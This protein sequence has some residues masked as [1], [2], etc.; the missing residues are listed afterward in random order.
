MFV[1]TDFDQL[2]RKLDRRN[3]V[4]V[5]Q[6]S[7]TED[8][9]EKPSLWI[10]AAKEPIRKLEIVDSDL[11]GRA[12]LSDLLL[13]GPDPNTWS[14]RKRLASNKKLVATAEY[15]A[16]VFIRRNLMVNKAFGLL[17]LIAIAALIAAVIVIEVSR[18]RDEAGEPVTRQQG[19]E[20]P[21]TEKDATL[22]YPRGSSACVNSTN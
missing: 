7:R 22:C 6:V 17:T 10:A 12:I 3:R 13:R 1:V 8:G 20:M 16:A 19:E 18:P 4:L 5:L 15:K 11:V 9:Q 14:H 2:V 21:E